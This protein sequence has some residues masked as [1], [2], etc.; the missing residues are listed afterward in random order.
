MEVVEDIDAVAPM[1]RVRGCWGAHLS[2]LVRMLR[3]MRSDV[4]DAP[5]GQNSASS[6]WRWLSAQDPI[7]CL[8]LRT[9][10]RNHL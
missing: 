2:S 1:A 4:T 5:P 8:L 6:S 9:Q 10:S 3:S 7:V